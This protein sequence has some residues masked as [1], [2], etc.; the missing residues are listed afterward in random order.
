[1]LPFTSLRGALVGRSPVSVIGD[2]SRNVIAETQDSAI[3]RY[4]FGAFVA[5]DNGQVTYVEAYNAECS[6]ETGGK[7][8]TSA[9]FYEKPSLRKQSIEQNCL[10]S[11]EFPLLSSGDSP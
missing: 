5:S 7:L 9:E 8:L 4:S 10:I 1:A 11:P 3:V 6:F 2:V